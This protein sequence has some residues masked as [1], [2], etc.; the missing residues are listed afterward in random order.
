MRRS[1]SRF[2]PLAFALMAVCG[3]LATTV[4]TQGTASADNNTNAPMS[5]H[6]QALDATPES[7][8]EG[9]QSLDAAVAAAVIGAVSTQFGDREVGVKLDRVAVEPASLQDRSVS[10]AGRLNISDEQ[11]AYGETWIPFEFDAMYDTRSATVTYPAL[12]LGDVD[13]A[14]SLALGSDV[15]RALS[16]KVDAALDVEFADQPAQMVI[17]RVTT[18]EF[19]PR[20]LR[21]EAMGTADFAAEG[22]TPAQVSAM[23]DR[24]TGQWLRL[25]YELG[26]TSNWGDEASEPA[27]AAR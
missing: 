16:R 26:T 8:I 20:Y 23:Y 24:K 11:G 3:V 6:A 10:G 13:A 2:S 18:S 9:D 5:V 25:D 12:V 27:V 1:S 4:A 21:V 22:T 15:A 19:G 17:H 7:R 14:E